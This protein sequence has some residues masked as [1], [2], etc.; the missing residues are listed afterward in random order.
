MLALSVAASGELLMTSSNA[1][2]GT[3]RGS[4]QYVP[5]ARRVL[6]THL[7]P[8]GTLQVRVT[9]L[10]RGL[11]HLRS[12]KH[13]PCTC[14]SNSTPCVAKPLRMSIKLCRLQSR[15]SPS[16][17]F[18]RNSLDSVLHLSFFPRQSTGRRWRRSS[19]SRS[20]GWRWHCFRIQDTYPMYSALTDGLWS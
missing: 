12:R 1:L 19:S 11:D 8:V 17:C 13:R 16:R 4:N 6:E 7:R 15:G 10:G 9:I 2:A 18:L 20:S 14:I 3:D 5:R